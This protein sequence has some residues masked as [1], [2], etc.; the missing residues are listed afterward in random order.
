MKNILCFGDS[1]TFGYDPSD[2]T[3]RFG[4]NERWTK[5]LQQKLGSN[6]NIIEEGLNG[7][8]ISTFDPRS[9][10]LGKDHLIPCINSH[11]PL[12]LIIVMLGTNEL[13][14]GTTAEQIGG[15]LERDI[16]DV[17][18]QHEYRYGT[19]PKILI[20]CPAAVLSEFTSCKYSAAT[21]KISLEL[22]KAF[23]EIAQRKRVQYLSAVDLKVGKD[24]VH[25]TLESHAEL[26]QRLFAKITDIFK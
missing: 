4:I 18:L 21:N 5:L 14:F 23:E 12:D 3:N 10:R 22:D 13:K 16:I 25:L 2:E 9:N 20:I 15:M 7:R 1:N 8:T 26:A 11:L 19:K 17:L 24:G 6:F